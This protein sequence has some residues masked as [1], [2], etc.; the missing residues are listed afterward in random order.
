[1]MYCTIMTTPS[2]PFN[3]STLSSLLNVLEDELKKKQAS[4]ERKISG[5]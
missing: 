5:G 1:M 2:A 3:I 4:G